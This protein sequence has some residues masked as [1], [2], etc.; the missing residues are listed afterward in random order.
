MC[1]AAELALAIPSGTSSD[2]AEA[3]PAALPAH[4]GAWMKDLSPSQ[5]LPAWFQ[6]GGQVRGRFESPSGTSLANSSNDNYYLSRIRVDLTVKP[7]AWLRFFVQAQ[8]ARVGAYNTAPA[9]TTLYDPMD[10]RQGYLAFLHEGKWGVQLRAGRQEMAF[11]S[12][13]VIGPADWGM[14]RTFDAVDL[15]ISHGRAKVDLFAGSAVQIDSTRF[16][17]HKPG[18]HVYGAYG[19][20]RNVLPNMTLEPYILFKQTLVIR[21]EDGTPGDGLVASPG[22]RVAGKAPGRLDYILEVLLQRGSYSAD[23]VRSF[24]Q[25][26]VAGWTVVNT[27]AKPRLSVEY[28]YASGDATQKDGIRGTF[29]Q[30]CPSNDGYYGMIDQFGWKNLKDW[31]AGFDCMLWKKLKYRADFNEFYLATVQDG[32]YGSSG[33]SVV[34]NRKATSNHVGSEVNTTVLYQWTRIWKFGA[35]YGRL[36]AGNFL[37]QSK[38]D[39][40]YNYP[41]VMFV[42]TF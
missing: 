35:G 31:R 34:L 32:L 41:Y 28:S 18:E 27:A 13:R 11:G 9:P 2:D 8:D 30:F 6:V 7:V 25:S 14:S 40:S 33:S 19:S 4:N 36:F 16:D 12:E 29:D 20:I 39:F 10:L 17:R 23:R 5:L 3:P 26:Y 1:V 15:S 21:S 38:A 24:G 22:A 37:K 42:G